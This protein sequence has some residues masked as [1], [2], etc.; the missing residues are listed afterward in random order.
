MM[1]ITDV[2]W[3]TSYNFFNGKRYRYD[4]LNSGISNETV[5]KLSAYYVYVNYTSMAESALE[6][7][8]YG[9][10]KNKEQ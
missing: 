4:D 5:V 10:N 2:F 9:V 3:I 1:M 8:T 7:T 6:I